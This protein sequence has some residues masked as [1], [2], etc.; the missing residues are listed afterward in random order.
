MTCCFLALA[1]ASGVGLSVQKA[2]MAVGALRLKWFMAA[3]SFTL[4]IAG[5]L[6]ILYGHL[7][8][9][10]PYGTSIHAVLFAF[11][12]LPLLFALCK[13]ED[14]E[15]PSAFAW[16]DGAQLALVC[17]LF[18][19]LLYPGF[20]MN[21]QGIRPPLQDFAAM[22]YLDVENF[23]L[24]ALA[25]A[26]FYAARSIDD[27]VYCRALCWFLWPMNL[28]WFF[29]THVAVFKWDVPAGSVWFVLADLPVICFAA[30]TVFHFRFR[31]E[32]ESS[33]H[34]EA[35][36]L[37]RI[38]SSVFLPV[39]VLLLCLAIA[40]AGHFALIPVI[41]SM[42][43]IFLFA[44]RSSYL[45]FRYQKSQ[46][47]LIDARNVMEMISHTDPLTGV[48]NRRW[49]DLALLREWKRAQRGKQPLTLLLI[50]IDHFKAFNDT[51]GHLQGDDCLTAVAQKLMSNLQRD[52]DSIVRYG[53]EEFVVILPQT[54]IRGALTVAE[55]MRQAIA[56]M[57]YP[58]PGAPSGIVTVS[59]GAATQSDYS[60]ED[61]SEELLI[62]ADTALYRAKNGGR[63]RVEC[64]ELSNGDEA[65]PLSEAIPVS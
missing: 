22:H 34:V 38:G 59:V 39:S 1:Y 42:L 7:P 28:I 6:S 54:D 52:G 13:S 43:A 33:T 3:A 53:G 41:C 30:M 58:H 19:T 2:R 24:L 45:Q 37:I 14:G 47:R 62:A 60:M 31:I 63:N 10:G 21:L 25:T 5:Y 11:R 49:F 50:D 4:F 57:A 8:G 15:E 35:S 16:I 55:N 32:Q 12:G 27:K 17:F 44:I 64:E 18:V 23:L 36:A 40:S 20:T 26:R 65:P 29:L 9:V 61:T 56:R 46:S 48:H 51:L